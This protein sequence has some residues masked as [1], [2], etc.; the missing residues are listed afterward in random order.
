MAARLRFDCVFDFCDLLVYPA[1][2]MP[3]HPPL[4]WPMDLRIGKPRLRV[5]VRMDGYPSDRDRPHP[6]G[7][8]DAGIFSHRFKIVE[9]DNHRW[10]RKPF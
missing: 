4:E 9:L 6:H 3:V 5:Y 1:K 10:W 7:E 8:V 2:V